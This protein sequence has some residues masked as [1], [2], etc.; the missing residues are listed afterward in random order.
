MAHKL[1]GAAP[2]GAND[3]MPRGAIP[4]PLSII[5]FGALTNREAGTGDN[6]FG[7]KLQDAVTFTSLTFRA[8]TAD[9]SGSGVYKIQKNGSDTGVSG[10]TVT[11]A[12]ANQVAGTHASC[13]VT[14]TWSFAAGDVVTLVCVSNGGTAGKGLCVDMKGTLG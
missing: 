1:L 13:T 14:G 11:V 10:M 9:S 3:A 4:Y 8:A 2:S 6:P 7:V 12:A 5:G